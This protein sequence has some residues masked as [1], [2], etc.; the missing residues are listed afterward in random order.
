[1]YNHKIII[2][3][4]TRKKEAQNIFYIKEYSILLQQYLSYKKQPYAMK[5]RG[6]HS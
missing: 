1:M 4:S 2:N 6:G 5:K 3:I